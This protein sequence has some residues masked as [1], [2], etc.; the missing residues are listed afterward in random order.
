[1][2][3]LSK[4]FYEKQLD[5]LMVQYHKNKAYSAGMCWALPLV[6][7]GQK[8]LN[9]ALMNDDVPGMNTKGW[10]DSEIFRTGLSTISWFT[11]HYQDHY[12]S[13]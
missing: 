11:R 2:A 6:I 1:M 12:F 9:P 13:F 5:I 4:V 8:A 10:M 3:L 7:F